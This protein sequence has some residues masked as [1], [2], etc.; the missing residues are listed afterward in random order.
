MEKTQLADLWKMPWPVLDV[1]IGGQS[2][3]DVPELR[4]GTFKE[5][6][7]FLAAYGFDSNVPAERRRMHAILIEALAFIERQLILPKEWR[8]GIRPPDEILD[9]E[10]ARHLLLWASG[11]NPEERLKRAW[12]C[13]VMRVMHTIAHIEGVTKTVDVT[14]AREQIFQRFRKHIHRDPDGALWLGDGKTRVALAHVGWKDSKS[15]NSILLKLLHKRDN[16][17]ETLFDYVGIRIVTKRLCDVMLAVKCLRKFH[18]VVY[19]NAYPS[20]ARNNLIDL[21]R[22][23]AQIETLRDML[24]AGSISPAEFENMIGRLTASTSEDVTPVNPHSSLNYRA[25]QMTGRQLIRVRH[26]EFEWL[27]KLKRVLA[28]QKMTGDTGKVLSDLQNLVEG[29]YSVKDNLDVASFFPFEVQILDA[30]SYAQSLSGEANHDRYKLSQVRAARKR[31]L[32][33]VLELSRQTPA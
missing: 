10:D 9:C 15:R 1:L 33:K 24:T 30:E 7:D 5:A 23:R 31:V 21:K 27:D 11:K 32:S 4:V 18:M 29:W 13:A 2:S 17:A 28:T 8:R 16:V 14:V 26:H 25:I 12:A 22:F 20:R 6:T 3:I 19:P